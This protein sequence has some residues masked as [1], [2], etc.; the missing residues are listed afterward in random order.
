MKRNHRRWTTR[1]RL[2]SLEDRNLLGFIGPANYPAGSGPFVVAVGDVN[3]DG[4]PDL[5]VSSATTS[6]L[7][8]LYGTGGGNFTPGPVIGTPAPVYDIALTDLNG[9]GNLDIVTANPSTNNVSVYL[10]NG[11]GT[12]KVPVNYT[13]DTGPVSVKVGDFN[14]DGNLD[15]VTCNDPGNSVSVLLGNG[16]GTFRPRIDSPGG[17][18]PQYL[19]VGDFNGDGNLDVATA[20][21][22]TTNQVAILQGNGDGTFLAPTFKNV[23][24]EP[25]SIAVGDFNGDGNLDLVTANSAATPM[26]NNGVSVLLGN[27]DGTFQNAVNYDAGGATTAYSIAGADVNRDGN[28]DLIL[29]NSAT[30]SVSVLLGVGD[31]TFQ[32][33][34]P[35]AVD[36]RPMFVAVADLNG[37]SFPDIVTANNAAGTVSVLINDT[38][39]PWINVQPVGVGAAAPNVAS[40]NET[41]P[42]AANPSVLTTSVDTRLSAAPVDVVMASLAPF[43]HREARDVFADNLDYLFA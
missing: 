26:G 5:V 18:G 21:A 7:T 30:D 34:T 12:F 41:P 11:D 33:P 29:A 8:I 1:P 38:T 23:G 31:G 35:Y 4:T 6:T 17:V 2:E 39:A 32:P 37:D 24:P 15:L 14:G 20:D 40:Q 3:N 36:T 16:D 42:V 27:G 10:G 19:A 28:L 13:T 9:D 25:Y 43:D 22:R